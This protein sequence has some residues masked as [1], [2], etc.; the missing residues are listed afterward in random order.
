MKNPSACSAVTVIFKDVHRKKL[1]D[2]KEI[3]HFA[4]AFQYPTSY[5][6]IEF[7]SIWLTKQNDGYLTKAW[8][9]I[10][11]EWVIQFI[12]EGDV[13]VLGSLLDGMVGRSVISTMVCNPDIIIGIYHPLT[14]FMKKELT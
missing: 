11:G 5:K 12:E 6:K 7:F 4:I 10:K 14:G 8:E 1:R 2:S 3:L 13:G 9:D